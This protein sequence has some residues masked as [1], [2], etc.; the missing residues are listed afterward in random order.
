M[1]HVTDAHIPI[2]PFQMMPPAVAETFWKG[3]PNR[4]ALEGYAADP[5]GLLARM[6]AD[7]A[8]RVGP[9]NFASPGLTGF[10]EAANPWT[11][12]CAS[13]DPW[14]PSAGNVDAFM[15]LPLAGAATRRILAQNAARI[16]A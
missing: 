8:A 14:R 16:W 13:A 1:H 3:K 5:R 10:T 2:Q 15:A 4:A 6:D 11:I 7:A 9:I 12:R